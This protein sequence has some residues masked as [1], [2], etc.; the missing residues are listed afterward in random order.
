MHSVALLREGD[1][2]LP[3]ERH[4][5]EREGGDAVIEPVLIQP[6]VQWRVMLKITPFFRHLAD[7]FRCLPSWRQWT[8]SITSTV[9]HPL[10]G[11]SL[12]AVVAVFA[13]IRDVGDFFL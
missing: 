8:S 5:T 4:V 2:I 6:H 10:D 3:F 1:V 7:A 9:S 13:I 12:H 11:A